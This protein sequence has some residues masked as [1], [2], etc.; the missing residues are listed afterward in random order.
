MTPYAYETCTIGIKANA[1]KNNFLSLN[2]LLK[3]A[4]SKSI[5]NE[6]EIPARKSRIRKRFIKLNSRQNEKNN[7]KASKA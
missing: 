6:Y 7:M 5:I 1:Y 4:D 2:F 3:R